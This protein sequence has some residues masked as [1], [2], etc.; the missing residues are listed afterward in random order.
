MFDRRHLLGAGCALGL[1]I[2]VFAGQAFGGSYS[3]GGGQGT[4]YYTSSQT[5]GGQC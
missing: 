2:A 3:F 4:F 1:L 5:G